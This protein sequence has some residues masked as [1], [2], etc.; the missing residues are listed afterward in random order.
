MYLKTKNFH[1]HMSGPH[2]RDYHLMLDEHADELYAMTDPSLKRIRKLGGAT[3]RSIGHIARTQRV[4]DNDAGYVEPLDMLS[5][6]REDNKDAGG[7]PARGARPMRWAS[8]HRAAPASSKSGLTR[9]SAV[10]GFCSSRAG[11][12]IRAATDAIRP[13]RRSCPRC[14]RAAQRRS[15]GTDRARLFPSHS[16]CNR[17]IDHANDWKSLQDDPHRHEA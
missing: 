17:S 8:G 14:G 3:L 7:T 2:F 16:R 15:L 10:P 5:E 13:C 11:A 6:L 9:R 1:W 4:L 12:G